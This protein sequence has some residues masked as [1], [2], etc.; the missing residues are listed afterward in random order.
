[1]SARKSLLLL[2]PFFGLLFT[3][4]VAWALGFEISQSKEELNLR[5]ELSVVDHGTGRVTVNLIIDDTGKLQAL[6]SIDLVILSKDGTPR[7]DLLV[8]L[9]TKK[10]NGKLHV[11]AHLNK[12]LAERAQL[13]LKT[14]TNPRTGKQELLTWFYFPISVAKMLKEQQ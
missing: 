12:E 3:A 2:L 7:P 6:N 9:E 5:Y 11:R 1:M 13:Q 10:M 8:S 14:L 4:D